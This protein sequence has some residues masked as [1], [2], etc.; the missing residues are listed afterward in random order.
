M[1]LT[2]N[3][4]PSDLSEMLIEEYLELKRHFFM[5]DWGSGQLKGGR[6]AESLLRIYQ[7][8]L[9][10]PIVPFGSDIAAA[11]KTRILNA[12][13]NDGSIDDHVRQKTVPL[14]RLLLDFRNNRDVAHLG[15]F[16]A[17]SMDALF[18]MTGATWILCELVR[19]YGDYRMEQA[20]AIVE[21]LAVREYPVVI[22][23]NG[24]IFVARHD[25]TAKQEVLVLLIKNTQA[26]FD[27][28]FSKTRDR[29][30]SRFQKTLNDLVAL[31]LIGQSNDDY[32]L[33]PRGA[34]MVTKES[35]LQF[36]P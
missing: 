14:T 24:E 4:L 23:R 20:Q 32:F 2:I 6:F 21:G 10:E 22:E 33:M 35:L 1:A 29:N 13:Q 19:V 16:D 3:R 9:G 30:K 15:G 18:V 36:T 28:L 27:F 17:N 12:V 11:A 34:A 31:K 7:H 8:L 26:K 25:L 5:N